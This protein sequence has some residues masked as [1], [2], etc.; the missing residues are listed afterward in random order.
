VL[1]EE[2]EHVCVEKLLIFINFS[3]N[4]EKCAFHLFLEDETRCFSRQLVLLTC[5]LH[6]RAWGTVLHRIFVK[7]ALVTSWLCDRRCDTC[8]CMRRKSLASLAHFGSFSF[9]A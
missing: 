7:F 5:L 2:E 8:A 3:E 1:E 6:D 4:G 9:L